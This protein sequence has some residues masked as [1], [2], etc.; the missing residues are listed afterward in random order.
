MK[1]LFR[2]AR[3][4]ERHTVVKLHQIKRVQAAVYE[5]RGKLSSQRS[6]FSGLALF[7]QIARTI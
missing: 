5:C 3:A 6:A 7:R 4:R 2:D 1:S